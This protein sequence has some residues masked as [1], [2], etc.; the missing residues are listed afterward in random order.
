MRLIRT[1]CCNSMSNNIL[2]ITIHCWIKIILFLLTKPCFLFH[3]HVN[4]TWFVFKFGNDRTDYCGEWSKGV[5]TGHTCHKYLKQWSNQFRW[6]KNDEYWSYEKHYMN[7]DGSS[8]LPAKPL[9]MSCLQ[10]IYCLL[11]SS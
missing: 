4:R 10:L 5:K 1:N 7:N 11:Y 2:I 8:S 6:R 9:G 3:R